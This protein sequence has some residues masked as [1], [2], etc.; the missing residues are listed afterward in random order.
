MVKKIDKLILQAFIGPFIL[1]FAVVV[2]IL[3]LQFLLS[4]IEDLV[5]KNL[6]FWVYARLIGFFSI[7]MMPAAFPLAI[8]VSTLITFGNLGEHSELTAIKS[9]GISLLRVLKPIFIS[10]LLISGLNFYISNNLVPYAN[11]K[12]FSLLYDVRQKKPSVSLKE[13]SFYYGIPGY[14]IKVSEK[15]EE[16][17]KIKNIIIYN[18]SAGRGNTEVIF[19]D[20]GIMKTVLN[21]K[22][23]QM[24]L[25]NGRTYTEIT[26][27]NTNLFYQF[28][29][30]KFNYCKILFS[31]ESFKLNRTKEELFSSNAVMR[32]VKQLTKDVDSLKKEK[33]LL[34]NSI[35]PTLINL[36]NFHFKHQPNDSLLNTIKF[37]PKK[38][39][40]EIEKSQLIDLAL[41]NARTVKNYIDSFKERSIFV[42]KEKNNYDIERHRKFTQTIACIIMFL[43]G[44]PLG[45]IIK[46]GGLGLPLLVSIIFFVIYYLFS[47]IGT[48]MSKENAIPVGIGMW[49]ANII[50]LPIGLFFLKQAKNDSRLFE[51]DDLTLKLEK[52]FNKTKKIKFTFFNNTILK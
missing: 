15:D 33:Y 52:F 46:K 51:L 12:A 3:L 45:S 50:L 40:S 30:N 14:A 24:E 16:T 19:A 49:M 1:T 11:L 38:N 25:F 32:N 10:V 41:N 26:S 47:M 2:F 48:Q 36:L 13:G 28:V 39:L 35:F 4:Y 37:L 22:Y 31:L 42:N 9:S 20:S 18:H 8:L 6:G 44:A 5:G 23:L 21:E 27:E 34:E 43:I 29:R 17:G 7:N